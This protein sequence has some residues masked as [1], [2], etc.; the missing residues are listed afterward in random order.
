LLW[1]N[2]T[3]KDINDLFA[4]VEAFLVTWW[5]EGLE[6]IL[7]SVLVLETS[8]TDSAGQI[9]DAHVWQEVHRLFSVT[10]FAEPFVVNL[11]PLGA[12]SEITAIIA[13]LN[14]ADVISALFSAAEVLA[15]D[16]ALFLK[17]NWAI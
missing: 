6:G 8:F 9:L 17:F 7:N 10:V 5:A 11:P 14:P 12:V 2:L 13:F 3:I 4:S 1:N 16:V 15:E